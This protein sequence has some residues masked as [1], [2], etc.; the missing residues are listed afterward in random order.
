LLNKEETKKLEDEVNASKEGLTAKETE[1]SEVKEKLSKL[2]NK[3]FNFKKL[4]DM[5]KEE[6]DALTSKELELM[7]RQDALEEK[8]QELS[9]RV[10]KGAKEG[11]IEALAGE[12]EELVKKIEFH[13]ERLG[14]DETTKEDVEKKVREAHLL[15][16]SS[17]RL[18]PDPI[19]GAFAKTSSGEVKPE[20]KEEMTKGVL[21]VAGKLGI[22]AEDL[23]K[24]KK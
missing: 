2:E 1:L 14:G 3:D 11:A 13:F 15:A 6:L 17:E 12:D 5:K 7:K 9:D 18:K 8:A 16:T 21:D 4:R 20:D 23:K 24:Y 19:N 22:T 10:V